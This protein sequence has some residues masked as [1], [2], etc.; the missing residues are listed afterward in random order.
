MNRVLVFA[1][2]LSLLLPPFSH[3]A[4]GRVIRVFVALCD[5]ATQGIVKVN[6]RIGNGDNPHENLYWGCADSIKPLFKKSLHW[7]LMK[8]EKDISPIIL[9][10]LTFQHTTF[11]DVTLIA[12][13]YRGAKMKDCLTDFFAATGDARPESRPMT[14]VAFIGHNGLMDTALPPTPATP[15]VGKRDA[16]VLACRS[17]AYFNLRLKGQGVR[18]VL[19]TRCIMYPGAFILH[20]TLEGW[21]RSESPAQLRERAAKAY[22]KNQGISVASA[23]RIFAEL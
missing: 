19:M 1:I 22:A 2:L 18:P 21:L 17:E 13:A 10:R 4:E 5:N 16:M 23:S 9:E 12:E 20:D 15:G 14:F 8:E 6:P 7:K 11:E 3:G